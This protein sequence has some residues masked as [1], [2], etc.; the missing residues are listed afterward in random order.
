LGAQAKEKGA[1]KSF[2]DEKKANKRRGAPRP[3][4]QT[5]KNAPVEPNAQKTRHAN[6]PPPPLLKP[7]TPT[8]FPP[9]THHANHKK[10]FP[11][12]YGWDTVGL[13]ADPETFA[14]FREAEVIHARWAMLGALGCLTPELLARAG[15]SAMPSGGVWFKLQSAILQPGGLNYLGNPAL[16]HA[17]NG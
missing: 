16:I 17:Q 7:T 8:P 3:S 2:P 14:R 5:H 13:S 6:A 12:D 4:N 11:G 1:A 10:Q 15:N 9:K